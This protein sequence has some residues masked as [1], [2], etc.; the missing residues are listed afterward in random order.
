MRSALLAAVGHDLRR[1]LTVG[2]RR[3]SARSARPTS[4]CP[5]DQRDE[6]LDTAD[7]SLDALSEL[8]T[9]LLDVSRVQA[10]ALGVQLAA[11]ATSPTSILPALDELGLGPGDGGARPRRRPPARARR[12]G[13][14]AAR[15]REPARQRG[16]PQP[17]GRA[18]APR[19]ERVPR[20][21][22]AA[23]RRPRPRHPAERRDE[24]FT[25]FQRLGD[26]DND[27]GLGLGLALSKGFVEGMDGTLEVE[28]T[29]GG[30]LTMVVTLARRDGEDGRDEDPARRRRRAAA[31]RAAH[32]ARRARLRGGRRPRR[33]R[34]DRPRRERA[35]RPDPARPRHAEG[36]GRRRDPSR[37]R[38]VEGADPRAVGTHRL[39][40]EGR[41][42]R[43]RRR[44]LRHEAVRHGRAARP[45]P[46][47]LAGGDRRRRTPPRS[48]IGDLTVDL[49]AKTIRVDRATRRTRH[50]SA[51]R[52][53]SGACSS[54]PAEPGQAA[55]A[56]DAA[57][58]RCGVR[59][60]RTTPGY[61][62]LYVAQLR[63][64]LEPVPAEPRY[65]LTEPGMGY[66]FEP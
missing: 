5:T 29:P 27:T 65:F 7:E 10:G 26:T 44:R 35:P 49:A 51:S 55:H 43:C 20:P 58:A 23:R 62:R 52:P 25:P 41:G 31:A 37:A 42:A 63:R 57:D 19:R 33:R 18:R 34:G 54:I 9:N 64:K 12:R 30:G 16:A 47:A 8:V 50:P 59:T 3:R 24:V 66:R 1:P 45:H 14:A 60:T 22:R 61:L 28:D 17:G 38:L 48:S 6:L 13:A 4:S 15:R 32:H 46:R 39:G 40:R 56:A 11:D 21:R 36:R 53:P 2:D